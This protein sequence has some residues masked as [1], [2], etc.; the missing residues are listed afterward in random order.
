MRGEET[1]LIGITD[2]PEP[3]CLYVLPGSHSKMIYTDDK[4]RICDFSTGLSGEMIEAIANNTIL[5]GIVDLNQKECDKKYL[6]MG[7]MFAKENGINSALFKV[8]ILKKIFSCNDNQ[9]YSFFIGVV[10]SPEIESIKKTS[11]QKVVIGGKKQ[12]KLSISLLLKSNCEKEIICV[13]DDIAKDA[14]TY[15][16]IKIYE[17]F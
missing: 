12:L 10:L 4:G 7:Y 3:K 13:D 16:M 1:E 6:Q 17:L 14:A 9:V 5:K 11:A 8:R 2:R 15:G